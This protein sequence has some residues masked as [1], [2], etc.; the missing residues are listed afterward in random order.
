MEKSYKFRIYPN[1]EQEVL[2]QKTFGCCRFVYNYFLAQRM[3]AYQT[4]GRF[5]TGFQQSSELPALKKQYDWLKEADSIALQSSVRDLEDSFKNFFRRIRNGEYAGYP[6]FKSKRTRLQNY[7]TKQQNANDSSPAIRMGSDFIRLPKLGNV[8]CAVSKKVCGRILNVTVSQY[9][10]GKY[11]VSVCCADVEIAPLP[12][13]GAVVGVDLGIKDLA[14]T[15]DGIKYPNNRYIYAAEKKLAR[16]QR[17]L[18]RKSKG[19][20]RREKARIKVARLQEHIANQRRD[21]MQKL[22]TELVRSYDVIC[23]EDLNADGLKRN[24][25]LAK[26][27]A[28]ASFFEFRRELEYKAS[29]YGKTVQLIDTFFPSSQLCHCCGYRNAEVKTLRIREWVCSQCGAHHDRDVNAAQNIL[30]EGLRLLA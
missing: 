6:K 8:K 23:I 26:S 4:T 28:D 24:H 27:I 1:R 9:P 18:S 3:N 20:N 17:Q 12:S 30:N 11:Y 29:W 2:I 5:L 19:S 14:I 21:T 25:K 22:T 13:T 15:S 16:L 7:K 10:S